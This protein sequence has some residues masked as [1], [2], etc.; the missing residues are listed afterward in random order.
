[1][2]LDRG[3]KVVDPPEERKA[4]GVRAAESVRGEGASTVAIFTFERCSSLGNPADL[5]GYE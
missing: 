2:N 3:V 5:S 1:M 4:S